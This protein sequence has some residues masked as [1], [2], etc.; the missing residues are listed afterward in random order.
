MFNMLHRALSA[1]LLRR[2]V[3]R[4][5]ADEPDAILSS[6][7]TVVMVAILSGLGLM[8]VVLEG[9]RV[10][11]MESILTRLINMWMVVV[12]L[13]I[14]WILWSLVVHM[15]GGK[16]LAGQATFREILRVLGICYGPGTLGLFILVPIVGPYLYLI[17][18]CWI[19]IIAIVA[20]HEVQSTDWFAA[21]ISTTLG[22]VISLIFIPFF[23][24]FPN[25]LAISH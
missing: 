19:L 6:F 12:T 3:F 15:V 23:I 18:Q 9:S 7:G 5:T 21:V 13:L 16:I 22:W 2:R 25:V 8:N 1:S 24:L 14:G 4:I 17:G 10:P 20:I 11:N